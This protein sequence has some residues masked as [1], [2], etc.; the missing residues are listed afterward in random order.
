MTGDVFPVPWLLHL[1]L[2][3]L[4]VVTSTTSF[5]NS[6][7]VLLQMGGIT[8]PDSLNCLHFSKGLLPRSTNPFQRTPKTPMHTLQK[9]CVSASR[10][11]LIVNFTTRTFILKP[12]VLQRILLSFYGVVR[13]FYAQRS[14]T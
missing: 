14:S 2:T 4:I 3:A 6:T 9:V 7:D 10:P 12:C 5:A 11:M 13:N 8:Q 1:C